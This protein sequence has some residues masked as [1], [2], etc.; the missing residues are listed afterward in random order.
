MSGL[1]PVE[2]TIRRL[3]TKV[4]T[5][6]QTEVRGLDV[7]LG[8]YLSDKVVS[9]FDVP[10]AD[11]S[12]MDGYAIHLS[13]LITIYNLFKCLTCTMKEFKNSNNSSKV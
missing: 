8:L 3:L 7:A 6:S 5:R 11:N 9:S 10:T 1:S 4:S 13:E 12:A 2:E